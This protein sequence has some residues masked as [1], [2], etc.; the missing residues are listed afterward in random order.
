MKRS[1]AIAAALNWLVAVFMAGVGVVYLLAR[2]PMPYHQKMLGQ[3]WSELP[4]RFRMVFMIFMRGTGM[5][6]ITTAVSLA[7]LLT[8]PFRRRENWSR[9]AI[10]IVGGAAIVPM[11]IGA[12]SL[13]A[14]TGSPAPWQPHLVLMA[15]MATA[16]W[17]TRDFASKESPRSP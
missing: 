9:A 14:V 4:E 10:L 17:L 7:I 5:V 6:G 3:P 1:F 11:F 13:Q 12:L 15:V 2:E 8:I 16:F